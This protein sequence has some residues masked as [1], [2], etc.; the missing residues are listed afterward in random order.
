[1]LVIGTTADYIQ[2]IR[3]ARPGRAVY[4]TSPEVRRTAEEPAP[5]KEEEIVC[6]LTDGESVIHSALAHFETFGLDPVGVACFDCESMALA[7]KIASH[8]KLS[9]PSSQSIENCRNKDLSKILWRGNGVDCP[10]SIKVGSLED[11]KSFFNSSGSPVVIKPTSGSGSEL[12]FICDNLPSCETNYFTLCRELG[13]RRNNR[14]YMDGSNGAASVVAESYIPGDEY[15]C[16]FLLE[17]EGVRV[18]RVAQKIRPPGKP[19]GTIGGYFLAPSFQVQSIEERLPD[20]LERAARAIGLESCIAMA[21]FIVSDDRIFF[22][23]ITPRP[24]GDCLPFLLQ[25]ACGFD[26][27]S[28]AV[29]LGAGRPV[30]LPDKGSIRPH[31]GI[32][33]HAPHSG[34]LKHVEVKPPTN[35][36]A[37]VD[38]KITRSTGHRIVMP[39]ADYDSWF[40]GHVVVELPEGVDP[41][42][43]YE[44][45][46]KNV[47]IEVEN[48][49]ERS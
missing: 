46:Q 25:S 48:E 27:L 10:N 41:Y 26:M 20:A 49:T 11:L 30:S 38:V 45:I 18:I 35:G 9:Y 23:E 47:L 29:D 32:R 22:L 7:A 36:P 19:F 44:R 17:R 37:I 40:L 14:L 16:D 13:E 24:G 21:D 28:T 39:P 31:L 15:S 2:W 8:F 1:M 12:V 43:E 6:D 5:S 33:L 4:I 3:S 34:Q 42:Q